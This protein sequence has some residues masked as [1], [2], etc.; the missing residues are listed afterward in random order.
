MKKVALCIGI[1][2][3]FFFLIGALKA[4]AQPYPALTQLNGKWLKMSGTAKGITYAEQYVDADSVGKFSY[5][6]KDQY[7]CIEYDPTQSYG[8]LYVY[9]KSGKQIGDAYLYYFAGT[10]EQ[11]TGELEYALAVGTYDDYAM[12]GINLIAWSGVN[13]KINGDA[14]KGSIKGVGGYGH[15][16]Y[17]NT[18][19]DYTGMSAKIN[20]KIIAADKL[21]FTGTDCAYNTD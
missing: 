13:V 20:A 2:M 6:F 5:N 4:Q 15:T 12:D 10:E 17:M 9:D 1:V 11:W 19:T 16:Q 8:Y 3:I 7:A 21:P 14:S 18:A